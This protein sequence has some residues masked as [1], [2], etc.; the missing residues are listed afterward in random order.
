MNGA[1]VLALVTGLRRALTRVIYMRAMLL[2]CG[3]VLSVLV[4]LD[5]LLFL[6]HLKHQ[7]KFGQKLLFQQ[8]YRP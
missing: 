5:V 1:G 2:A 8:L 3:V 6:N 4:V 7:S